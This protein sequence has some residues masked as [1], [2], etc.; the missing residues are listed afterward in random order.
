MDRIDIVCRVDRPAP[1]HL[2]DGRR[3]TCSTQLAE[4]VLE[5]RARAMLRDGVPVS[6]LSGAALLNSCSMDG[7]TSD[8]VAEGSRRHHLSGRGIT[9]LLRLARVLA[10]LDGRE[11]VAPFDVAEAFGFRANR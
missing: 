5:A 3:G 9:R 8:L 10:D 4:T 1:A 2:L 6:A 11:R 7:T